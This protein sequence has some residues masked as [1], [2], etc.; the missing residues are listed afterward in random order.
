MITVG[1]Y[2]DVV[3]GKEAEFERDF[4]TVAELLRTV[5]GHVGSRLYRDVFRPTSYL[6]YSEWESRDAFRAFTQSAAFAEARRWGRDILLG[7]PRHTIL[8]ASV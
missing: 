1:M 8:E 2:Y 4:A 6:I 5:P 7:A 3:P